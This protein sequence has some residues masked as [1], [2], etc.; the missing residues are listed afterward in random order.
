MYC[1]SKP[2]SR[3]LFFLPIPPP[4]F[5]AVPLSSTVPSLSVLGIS[6]RFLSKTLPASLPPTSPVSFFLQI[7]PGFLSKEQRYPSAIS[8]H[9]SI[10]YWFRWDLV[11][12]FSVYPVFSAVRRGQSHHFSCVYR[13]SDGGWGWGGGGSWS[14]AGE[15]GGGWKQRHSVTILSNGGG[16]SLARGNW[17]R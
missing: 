13:R 12:F 3:S 16:S 5:P 2:S 9:R 6:F 14:E 15:G 17:N 1:Q 8:N 10:D 4:L 7:Q 11:I